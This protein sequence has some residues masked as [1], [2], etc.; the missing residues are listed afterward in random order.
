MSEEGE[1]FGNDWNPSAQIAYWDGCRQ[2]LEEADDR[3]QRYV[4]SL[5]TYIP[6]LA[7]AGL[8]V[9][10]ATAALG[11]FLGYV[12][13]LVI[14]VAGLG[15]TRES[16]LQAD[17]AFGT[18][19]GAIDVTKKVEASM[20]LPEKLRMATQI[21]LIRERSSR[22]TWGRRTLKARFD[23]FTT[24]MYSAFTVL[25]TLSVFG[26]YL[27]YSPSG[28]IPTVWFDFAFSIGVLASGLILPAVV[29]IK[30]RRKALVDERAEKDV[31]SR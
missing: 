30:G 1:R 25:I 19:Q 14:G 13:G 17:S 2:T 6:A 12:A 24:G 7:A 18:L 23:D 26:L 29:V 31:P 5:F 20:R 9:L 22:P 10:A 28:W 8:S 11:Y 4:S 3:V 16:R 27:Q 21:G 15:M